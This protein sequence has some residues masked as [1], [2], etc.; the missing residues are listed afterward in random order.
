MSAAAAAD[1]YVDLMRGVDREPFASRE[2]LRN[3]QRTFALRNA[4]I[5][6]VEAETVIVNRVMRKLDESG[7]IDKLSRPTAQSYNA[8]S[9]RFSAVMNSKPFF[10]TS[11][12]CS[13]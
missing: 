13:I 4:K 11:S 6:E 7:F 2:G 10:L 1:A 8:I 3:V 9:S 12:V 5:S